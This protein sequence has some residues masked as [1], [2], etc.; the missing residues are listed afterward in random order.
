MLLILVLVLAICP[1][2]SGTPEPAP[3]AEEVL[4][5]TLGDT[6]E[7]AGAPQELRYCPDNTC[8]AFASDSAAARADFALLY[9][10]FVSS[11]ECLR[12][13]RER[14]PAEAITEALDRNRGTCG[15][16]SGREVGL[17]VLSALAADGG[18]RVYSLRFDEGAVSRERVVQVG[19]G[20]IEE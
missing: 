17:C 11:Y 14:V 7:L 16:G 20:P 4:R 10:Y 1:A 5:Q 9:L 18:V 6:I 2:G 13:W 8:E 19:L 12:P 15:R 3:Q